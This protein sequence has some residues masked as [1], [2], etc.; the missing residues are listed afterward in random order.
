MLAF[1]IRY[2]ARSQFKAANGL[3]AITL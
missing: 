1:H 2:L 3:G